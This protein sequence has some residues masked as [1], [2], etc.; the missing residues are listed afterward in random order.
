MATGDEE[1]VWPFTE[2][3]HRKFVRARLRAIDRHVK[4][5][6]TWTMFAAIAAVLIAG[7]L[8]WP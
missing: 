3:E 6:L 5:I 4:L 2:E 1:E 7:K 8:L